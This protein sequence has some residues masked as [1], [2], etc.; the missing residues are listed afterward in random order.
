[1]G[2]EECVPLVKLTATNNC[3]VTHFYQRGFIMWRTATV[4]RLI[5]LIIEIVSY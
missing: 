4:D 3:Q 2:L 5:E 1:M